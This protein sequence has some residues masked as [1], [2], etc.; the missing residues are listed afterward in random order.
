MYE[1][2]AHVISK[3]DVIKAYNISSDS[4]AR[5]NRTA[6]RMMHKHGENTCCIQR[7]LLVAVSHKF[8]GAHGATDV[9]GFGL[10]GHASNLVKAQKEAVDFVIH[11]LPGV[12]LVTVGFGTALRC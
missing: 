11:T 12:S 4:M 2:I 7:A 9:T 3:E 1:K 6:A 8:V 5:L 10:L